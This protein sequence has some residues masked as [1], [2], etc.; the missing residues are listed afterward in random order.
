M[1]LFGAQAKFAVGAY[2]FFLAR[3]RRAC[4][5][6]PAAVFRRCDFFQAGALEDIDGVE[7]IVGCDLSRAGDGDEIGLRSIADIR[8]VRFELMRVGRA[9]VEEQDGGATAFVGIIRF[10]YIFAA[11]P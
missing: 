8:T 4:K 11:N 5:L 10:G 7:E 9:L 3:G 6:R 2:V 1:K